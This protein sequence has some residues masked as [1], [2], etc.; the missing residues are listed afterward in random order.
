RLA[1]IEVKH[2]LSFGGGNSPAANDTNRQPP[3]KPACSGEILSMLSKLVEQID[4]MVDL[5]LDNCLLLFDAVKGD[6]FGQVSAD[7][8]EKLRQKLHSLYP[9]ASRFMSPAEFDQIDKELAEADFFT[10][11]P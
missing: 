9:Y 3:A 4:S 1:R 8:V 10:A 5:T 6:S 2:Q 7:L 11:E